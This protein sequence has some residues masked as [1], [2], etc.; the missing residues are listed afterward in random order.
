M[1]D[2][3]SEF[4]IVFDT[5]LHDMKCAIAAEIDCYNPETTSSNTAISLMEL[6]TARSLLVQKE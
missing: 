4:A 5:Q 1:V 2:A 6:K 3:T